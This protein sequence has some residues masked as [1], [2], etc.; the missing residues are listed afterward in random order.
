MKKDK[1]AKSSESE[2]DAWDLRESKNKRDFS[3][4]DFNL[5]M[6]IGFSDRIQILWLKL[7]PN[8][9]KIGPGRSTRIWS[10]P[11]Y[12][13]H[14][15]KN[16][17]HVRILVVGPGKFCR[18][19]RQ[20]KIAAFLTQ[21]WPNLYSSCGCSLNTSQ[22]STAPSSV[23]VATTAITST[24]PLLSSL[25]TNNNAKILR[26]KAK[27]HVKVLSNFLWTSVWKEQFPHNL[28]VLSRLCPCPLFWLGTTPGILS[29]FDNTPNALW[30]SSDLRRSLS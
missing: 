11:E 6:Y 28:D 13:N 9:K 2:R 7:I 22:P 20:D 12:P 10:I 18:V 24:T 14:I 30:V 16:L 23:L 25:L 3:L 8:M 5:I 21:L 1:T 15:P 4:L 27:P 26:L 29:R 19:N 17:G